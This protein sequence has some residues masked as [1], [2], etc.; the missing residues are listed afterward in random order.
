LGFVRE[1]V[2]DFFCKVNGGNFQHLTWAGAIS[3]H[4]IFVLNLR[5]PTVMV[6]A[7]QIAGGYTRDGALLGDIQKSDAAFLPKPLEP[8]TFLIRFREMLDRT[9]E[10]GH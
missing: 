3:Q 5:R 8:E 4:G 2:A 7:V 1:P 6:N 9:C 10:T